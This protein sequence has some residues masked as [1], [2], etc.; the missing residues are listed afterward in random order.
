[1]N[2]SLISSLSTQF[3]QRHHRL[4]AVPNDVHVRRLSRLSLTMIARAGFAGRQSLAREHLV[5]CDLATDHQQRAYDLVREHHA[6]TFSR[7]DRRN[8][9]LSDAL[10]PVP[11]FV[12][13]GRACKYN[14]A[15]TIGQDSKTDTDAKVFKATFSLNQ[16][17]SYEVLTV[18]PCSSVNTPDGSPLGAE[19]LY[20]YL[21]SDT[22]AVG[23]YRRVSVQRSGP[24]ANIHDRGDMPE[25]FTAGH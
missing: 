8:S 7:V 18:G 5:Y 16:T 14:T 9:A 3:G 20:L 4:A 6:L 2:S 13:S 24:C 10:R 15:S 19:P 11:K 1:M 17:G 21:R 12:V 25:G 23:A 22:P